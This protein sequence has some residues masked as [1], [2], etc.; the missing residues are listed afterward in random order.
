MRGSE[1]QNRRMSG[2]PKRITAI[3]SRPPLYP[4]SLNRGEVEQVL[5]TYVV[6]SQVLENSALKDFYLDTR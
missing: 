5:L 6:D 1:N 2:M 4:G 3:R